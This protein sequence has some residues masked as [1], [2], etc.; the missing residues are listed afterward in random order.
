MKISSAVALL[1]LAVSSY[2][3]AQVPAQNIVVDAQN[4]SLEVRR[5]APYLNL[6]Q[7]AQ[8]SKEFAT[9]RGILYGQNPGSNAS[10]TCVSRDNDGRDPWVLG[11]RSGL[12]VSRIAA[13]YYKTQGDCTTA[14]NSTRYLNGASLICVSRDNDG[15]SPYQLGVLG[16]DVTRLP[17]TMT[18]SAAACQSLM[19]ALRPT[20]DGT[21][22]Y[23][24]AR[25]NDGAAPYQ[26]VSLNL[27]NLQ[28]TG[29]SE[30]YQSMAACQQ[31]LGN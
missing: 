22:V 25:D 9:I 8:I 6:T 26:A 18:S 27:Q 19:Q 24:T 1:T 31:F 5:Q 10:Y 4:L 7:Q 16:N 20:R 29:G 14:L 23:C 12:N 3:H 13:G 11:I 21:V 2:A 17:R 15:A 30:T 28:V